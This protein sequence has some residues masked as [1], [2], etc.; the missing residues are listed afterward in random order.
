MV[1]LLLRFQKRS[2]DG[3]FDK[4]NSKPDK[5]T[6]IVF[7]SL[8]TELGGGEYAIYN[9]LKALDRSKY[10]P[11]M[12]FNKRGPFVEK[13]ESL[14]IE[15]VILQYKTVMLK[16]LINPIILWDTLKTSKQMYRFLKERDV[17]IIHCFDVLSLIYIARSVLKL[18]I[19]VVYNVIFFYEWTRLLL[20]NISAIFFIR[21]ILTDSQAVRNDLVSRTLFLSNKIV[22]IYKAVDASVFRSRNDKN[23]N[24][25]RK[26]LEVTTNTKL[27]G[28]VARF[29]TWKGH[30]TFL[31]AASIML[32]KRNDLK[33]VV[34]GGLLNV[35]VVPTLKDYYNEVMQYRRDLGLEDKVIFLSH[36]DDIP[37]VLC[38]LDVFVCPSFREPIPGVILEAMASNV[39]IVASDSGGNVEQIT[40]GKDGF[41]FRTGDAFA[42]VESIESCLESPDLI[43]KLTAE[44]RKRVENQFGLSRYGEEMSDLYQKV[45]LK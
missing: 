42:L 13:V 1:I 11:I 24:K 37:E 2:K 36:R 34:V 20:L 26:E 18:R 3:G 6:T 32:S 25:F 4:V 5:K 35:D 39:P 12:M 14:G 31:E 43:S 38:G 44:A 28:M 33:F 29:D 15:T 16:K 41:L 10:K 8:Y 21:K 40:H 22:Q 27:I 23:V 19:P 7:I 45:L 30:K 17:D 9:L